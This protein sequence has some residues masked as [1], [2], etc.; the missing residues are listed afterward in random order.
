MRKFIRISLYIIL[1]S[2]ILIQFFRPEKNLNDEISPQDFL[3]MN[4]NMPENL[5][6]IFKTSCYDCH[7]DNTEYP[8]YA[9]ISPFSWIIDQHIRNGKAELNFSA[10]GTLDTKE[11]IAVLDEICEVL[12]DSIMPPENYLMLHPDAAIDA[13]DNTAICDWADDRA[14]NI[15]RG[16]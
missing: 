8:W 10:F 15:M 13:E 11:K 1:G 5:K 7:S 12:G 6:M 2:F 3:A 4:Q 14:F 16:R 9:S